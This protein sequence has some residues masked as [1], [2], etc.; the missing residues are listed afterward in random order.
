MSLYE[1]FGV[2]ALSKRLLLCC[3]CLLASS[4]PLKASV[5][6]NVNVSCQPT[7]D[8]MSFRV[9]QSFRFNILSETHILRMA[10]YQDGSAIFCLSSASDG[11]HRRVPVGLIQNRFIDQFMQDAP[12]VPFFTIVVR[13]GN[14]RGAPLLKYLL[15]LSRPVRPVLWSP[16]F[17]YSASRAGSTLI[18]RLT[19]PDCV[20]AMRNGFEGVFNKDGS[21]NT[22]FQCQDYTD[23]SWW[24]LGQYVKYVRTKGI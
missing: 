19:G 20:T 22:T 5:V 10:R 13:E 16:V 1:C 8:D 21:L 12:G 3:A 4:F 17:P 23:G 18:N 7:A 6:A 9:D 11:H 14:G 2:Q 24:T 15:D